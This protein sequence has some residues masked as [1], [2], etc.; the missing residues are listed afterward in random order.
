[1]KTP[2]YRVQGNNESAGKRKS[3]K[4]AGGNKWLRRA[5]TEAAHAAARKKNS[6]LAAQFW[7]LSGRRGKKRA[8]IAVGRTI[9]V[10]AYH[11]LKDEVVYADLGGDYFDRLNA[12][13]TSR[14]LV[15]RL[16]RMGYQVELKQLATAA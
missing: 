14:Q 15:K 9:L 1:M 4:T 11:I 2:Y 10:A 8:A 13:K 5:L 6:Y 3:G 7:R 16:E 12:E